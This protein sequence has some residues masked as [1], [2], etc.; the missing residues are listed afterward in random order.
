MS[1]KFI[2]IFSFLFGLGF[3][4]Q[5]GRAEHRGASIIPLYRRRLAVMLAIGLAHLFLLC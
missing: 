2:T 5:I 4:V 1:G 3:A